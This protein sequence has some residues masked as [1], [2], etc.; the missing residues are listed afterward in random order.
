MSKQPH[1]P[2]ATAKSRSSCWVFP[3]EIGCII[4]F[5]TQI[6]P[7]SF[8]FTMAM[9][10]KANL[11]SS[12]V[13]CEPKIAWSHRLYIFYKCSLPDNSKIQLHSVWKGDQCLPLVYGRI[14]TFPQKGRNAKT[15]I[16][17]PGSFMTTFFASKMEGTLETKEMSH[18]KCY[19]CQN[20][21]QKNNGFSKW[22]ALVAS[23]KLP[24]AW[25]KDSTTKGQ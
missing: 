24:H 11:R 13:G 19:N 12:W 18:H 1:V 8:K 2:T 16:W 6:N 4:K 5:W 14:K 10:G 23:K 9:I 21:A 20:K 17:F 22:C 15:R 3:T 7:S 25:Y